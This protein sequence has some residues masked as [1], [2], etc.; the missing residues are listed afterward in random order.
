[1][2]YN[3]VPADAVTAAALS[4]LG[5]LRCPRRLGRLGDAWKS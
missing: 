2:L 4:L 3:G 5:Q 1:M